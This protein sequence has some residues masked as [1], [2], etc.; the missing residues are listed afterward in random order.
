MQLVPSSS[1][2]LSH[3]HTPSLTRSFSLSLPLSL[4]VTHT[5]ARSPQ[6]SQVLEIIPDFNAYMQL[7]P[8]PDNEFKLT[9]VP[10]LNP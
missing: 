10:P 3:A 1:L 8:M 7:V 9:L 5:R 6:P 4:S 2:S